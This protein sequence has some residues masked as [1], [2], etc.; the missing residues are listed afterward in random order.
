MLSDEQP[1]AQ[2]IGKRTHNQMRG[3][4]EPRV[5]EPNN[6]SHSSMPM[7]TVEEMIET[8]KTTSIANELE[9]LESTQPKYKSECSIAT[10]PSFFDSIS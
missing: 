3:P 1:Q 6:P 4:I 7:V 9:Y 5:Y 8:L 2:L 10:E